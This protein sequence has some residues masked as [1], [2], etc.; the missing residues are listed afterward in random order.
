MALRRKPREVRIS[1]EGT[2]RLR[3]LSAVVVYA[4]KDRDAA[5]PSGGY[6]RL[7]IVRTAVFSPDGRRVVGLLVKRPDVA[8]MVKRSDMFCALDAVA[9][10]DGGLRVTRGKDAYDAE[11]HKRLSLDWDRCII[12][13]GMDAKTTNGRVLGFVEDAMFDAQT[14]DVQTICIGDGNVAQSLVGLVEAPVSMLEGYQDGY[15]VLSPAA[16]KLGLSGGVAA[17]AGEGY[18]KAKI[19]GKQ[20]ADRAREGSEKAVDAASEAVDRGSR[21]LGKQLGRTKGMFGAFVEEYKKASK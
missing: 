1:P 10:C 12:W 14:G 9:P 7:G 6:T 5:T 19:A 21:A 8:G 11:A 13:E 17:K 16:A 20:A 2:L 18:A 15:L 3:D 4:P